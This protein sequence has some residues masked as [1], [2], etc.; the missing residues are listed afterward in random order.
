VANSFV[1]TDWVGMESLRVLQN[2]LCIANI[3]N[4]DYNKEFQKSFAIGETVR[5]KLPQRFTSRE[6]LGYTPQA[7]NR[8]YTTVTCDQVFGVDFEWDSVEE[9]LKAERGMEMFKKEYL[10]PAMVEIAQ[11]IESRAANYAYLNTNNITGALGTNPTSMA[12]YSGARARLVQN[13]CPAGE[14]HLV[15]SPD[16]H[17]SISTAVSTV[18]NPTGVI[19]GAFNTGKLGQG[20]GFNA[21]DESVSLYSHTAGTWAG[22][23][24]TSSASQSGSSINLTATTGDTFKAGDVITFAGVNN[25]NPVTRRSTG[26]LKQFVIL[27]D[28]TAAASAA[29]ITISP[30]IVGPGSQYQNVDALPANGADLTLMPGTTSPNGKS[31]IQ[32]LALHRDAFALVA[33]PLEVPKAVEMG[34]AKRD[35]S[36]GISVRF[37]RMFDPI[38]SKM[39]NRFDVL[40]GFGSLYPDNCAVRVQSLT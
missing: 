39:V 11:Q 34:V 19:S 31:G 27:Q 26:A 25:V 3:F 10:D 28:V 1:F 6:G 9:A 40:M 33:V 5:V 37:V 20:A 30:A 21:W 23:V 14:K 24:E 8:Q 16:M 7:I 13:A 17:Q 15:I 29:T 32:G 12:T 4:T 36:T 18:F 35:P 22:T 38:Q 2:N